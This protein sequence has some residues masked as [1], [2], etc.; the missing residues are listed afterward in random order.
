MSSIVTLTTVGTF[1]IVAASV[2]ERVLL[3]ASHAYL[4]A[5]ARCRRMFVTVTLSAFLDAYWSMVRFDRMFE[6]ANVDDLFE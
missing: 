6:L 4:R 5:L 3:T 2:F 1:D